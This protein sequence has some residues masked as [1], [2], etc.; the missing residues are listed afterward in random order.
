VPKSKSNI[1]SIRG[2]RVHHST[3]GAYNMPSYDLQYPKE[4]F[5]TVKRLSDRG[6]ESHMTPFS[7]KL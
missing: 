5:S 6:K 1:R 7:Y 2:S 4:K 3:A